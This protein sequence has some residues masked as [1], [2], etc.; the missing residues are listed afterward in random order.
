MTDYLIAPT[1]QVVETVPSPDLTQE[2]EE[3]LDDVMDAVDVATEG[4]SAV[5]HAIIDEV[6]ALMN[7]NRTTSTKARMRHR[8]RHFLPL[9]PGVIWC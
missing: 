3:V 6:E 5:E 2:I 8:M 1:G 4:E 9:Q 7:I